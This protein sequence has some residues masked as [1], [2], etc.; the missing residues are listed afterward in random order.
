[1]CASVCVRA[2]VCQKD[3]EHAYMCV[4]MCVCLCVLLSLMTPLNAL[5]HTIATSNALIADYTSTRR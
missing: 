3:R 1:V 4:C 5:A 2:C